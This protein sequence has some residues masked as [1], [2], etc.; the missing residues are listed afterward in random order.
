M[1]VFVAEDEQRVQIGLCRLIKNYAPEH[2]LVGT[3]SN[4]DEALNRIQHLLPD[5]VFTDIKMPVMD[6]LT[7]IR[8]V[9]EQGLAT[10]FVIVS[11]HADFDFAKQ[12]ISLGVN[13][14]LLKPVTK[15]EL[16]D[17][18]EKV[19]I[20]LEKRIQKKFRKKSALRDQ[21][22]NVHPM[23]AKS[24][25]YIEESYADKISQRELAANVGLSQEYFSYL[26]ARDVGEKFSVFL[27]NYRIERAKELYQGGKCDKKDVPYAVGFTD[28]KYFSKVFHKATGMTVSQYLEKMADY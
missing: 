28:L 19:E 14:Y 3:A 9:R 21:Y 13:E 16:M 11:A 22:P 8:K 24:L 18:L 2:E 6:G 25:D 4:G 17:T 20:K 1:R 27:R 26:F 5:V 23:I 7:L 10:E 15:D 12:A